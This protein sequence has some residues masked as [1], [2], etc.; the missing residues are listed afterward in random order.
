MRSFFCEANNK[1]MNASPNYDFWAVA[2]GDSAYHLEEL[3][4]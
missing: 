4:L 2:S 1:L 3:L